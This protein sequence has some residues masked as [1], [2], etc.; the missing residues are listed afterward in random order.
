MRGC[1]LGQSPWWSTPAHS[2]IVDVPRSSNYSCPVM[3]SLRFSFSKK[4]MS[5]LWQA[6]TDKIKI[7]WVHDWNTDVLHCAT[8]HVETAQLASILKMQQLFTMFDI[9]QRHIDSQM[10]PSNVRPKLQCKF[11]RSKY[12]CFHHSIKNYISLFRVPKINCN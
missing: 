9:V 5:V 7:N 8:Y 10:W 11:Q 12:W 3:T 2:R 4:S 1:L 6:S